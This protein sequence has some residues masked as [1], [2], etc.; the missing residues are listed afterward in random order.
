M[1][2][3]SRRRVSLLIR[4]AVCVAAVTWLVTQSQWDEFKR[5][6][7]AVNWRLALASALAFGPA[8]VIISVRLKW[9]LEVHN[10][11]ISVWQAIKVTFAGNF[12]IN[13]LPV[14]TSGG[15][16]VKAYYVARDTPHKHEAVTSV[17]FDRFIGVV[18]LVG[19]SGIVLLL[20]WRNP[21]FAGLGQ[22]IAVVAL[23]LVGGAGVYFSHTMRRL[24]RLEKIL[25]VLPF[26]TH[27]QRIDRAAF[28]F[29][30]H[31]GRLIAC[32]IV[33]AVLQ[34]IVVISVFLAGWALNMV[35]GQPL[36]A[37]PVYL[38]YTPV[39]LLAGALP[40]GVMEETFKQLFADAAGFGTREAAISLSLLG[41]LI[42]LVWS[43]PGLL[44][45]LGAGRP[46]G[47]PI[48]VAPRAE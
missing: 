13:T 46:R 39:C 2:P 26:T 14:G 1:T 27:L 9:L 8:P 25:S 24:L 12:I 7:G 3:A 22:V 28:A 23:V 44:V 4:W 41:R 30:H 32:L 33:T 15:D 31:V 20:H 48:A 18:G 10:V 34:L 45:V 16:A 19:M 35:G 21:A 36:A 5:V 38:A 6:L 47:S 11:E 29:R 40:I 42:Q 43:V 17:L 37:L